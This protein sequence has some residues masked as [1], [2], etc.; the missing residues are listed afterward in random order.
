MKKPW[1]VVGA[2]VL[3]SFGVLVSANAEGIANA[4]EMPT[5]TVTPTPIET[6]SDA[7]RLTQLEERQALLE[8]KY[9]ID[10][11]NAAVKAKEIGRATGRER[12]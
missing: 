9:E 5:T 8:R 7:D 11:E 1:S 6:L 2:I 12:G 3:A 4:V 10:Q